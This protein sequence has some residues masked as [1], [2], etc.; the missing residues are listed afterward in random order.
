MAAALHMPSPVHRP[1]M[2]RTPS[3][4]QA[5]AR[6]T[7]PFSSPYDHPS[8]R[9]GSS[10]SEASPYNQPYS[11]SYLPQPPPQ[12]GQYYPNQAWSPSGGA[13]HHQQQ[14]QQWN[15][16]AGQ[17]PQGYQAQQS[18]AD[19]AAWANA[20]QHMV[21]MAGQHT[22]SPSEYPNGPNGNGS[23]KQA[24][25][26]F[27]GGYAAPQGQLEQPKNQVKR[28]AGFHPYKRGPAKVTS[29]NV[30]RSAS[31]PTK[32]DPSPSSLPRSTSAPKGL[33]DQPYPISTPSTLNPPTVPS[34]EPI[35]SELDPSAATFVP[36]PRLNTEMRRN[37]NASERSD[38]ENSPVSRASSPASR[39]PTTRAPTP[40]YPGPI[41]NATNARPSP[42][43]NSTTVEEKLQK[44]FK[45]RL[46]KGAEKEAKEQKKAGTPAKRSVPPQAFESPSES[47][48]RSGT[49]P[50]TPPQSEP[51]AAPNAP[52]AL[53]PAASSSELSLA[54]TERTA[55]IGGEDGKKGKR[56]MFRMKNMS[57]DNISLSSTVSS[58][59]M[60][61]RKMGSIGKLARRNSLMGISRIFK[62]K[63][64]DEDAALPA[65]EAKKIKKE[66]KKGKG[67]SDAAPA[68]VSHATAEH[69]R[70]V[71]EEDDRTLAG[72]SPAAKLARQH[73]LK[74]RAEAQTRQQNGLPPLENIPEPGAM[75]SFASV[76][77]AVPN[78]G[79]EVVH[80]QPRQT[81]TVVHA[82][83][84]TEHEYDSEDDTSDEGDTVEDLTMTMGRTR[85]SDEADAE[86]KATWGNAYIDKNA[87][88]KKSILK[89][90][91]SH[92][93]MEEAKGRPRS[94]SAQEGAQQAPGPLAQLPTA[95]PARLDGMETLTSTPDDIYDPLSPSFS[96]F[97]QPAPNTSIYSIPSQNTSAP[98]LSLLGTS[99]RPV[100]QPRSMTVPAKRRLLWAPECAVYT[101]YDPSTYD[102][103]SEPATCN[104]LTPELAMSIKQELNAFKLEMPV[105]PESRVYTHYF[106]W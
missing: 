70:I 26:Y 3:L 98:T 2:D 27:E 10:A 35:R 83:A 22:P 68:S 59:S 100:P 45:S 16:Y 41:T 28:Q 51:L 37:S 73:T 75:P 40:L 47:S 5:R 66:K 56:S 53:N 55:T 34:A 104:R 38:R 42:L 12:Q 18:Q 7:P 52:F 39:P 50:I 102:R 57:T 99:D 88:P 29:D 95:D 92:A 62:D 106:A 58:A 33:D 103:R 93:S 67:K 72:L 84:V 61:I 87:V 23:E 48:T 19:F 74:S 49:P 14:Q 65:K 81:P 64:K 17:Y 79:P 101:T 30:P 78:S 13:Y 32:T 91:P 105:H 82:V 96:P 63:P 54:E 94:N 77:A 20:Y 43:S 97:D 8:S 76:A 86:F 80:V 11:N 25:E 21:M 46:F 15:Q 24:G 85:F 36:P 44:G 60:M 71:G 1:S 90:V 89:S 6:S 31:M 69:D 4:D 9:P